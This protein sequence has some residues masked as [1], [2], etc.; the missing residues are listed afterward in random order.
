MAANLVG[1]PA[2]VGHGWLGGPMTSGPTTYHLVPPAD[3][4]HPS[5]SP[6]TP[7]SSASSTTRAARCS[8]SPGP[9]P[10]RPPP[11]SRRS[12]TG[13]S[14]AAPTPPQVLALTF[15]RKAAES[16]A[17]GSRR[18][19]AAPPRRRCAR[20]STPSPTAW[21]ARYSPADL[22]TAPLRL[23]SAPE[24]DVVLRELLTDAPESVALARRAAARRSATRGF[25]ARGRSRCS[26]APASAAST[27]PT[28]ATSAG[29]RAVPEFVAAGL[30]LG[31]VPPGPRL[32][33]RHRLRRP[34]PRGP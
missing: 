3:R 15:S 23:L 2:A 18:G 21:S 30:F 9:A 4:R 8:C 34:D 6:S 28:C 25:A 27:R 24:Q 26:R 7:T 11:W 17:T 19:S 22:Y 16:C 20:P 1:H 33:E 10:A 31:P 29:A 14:S 5:R 12:P 13:S 32:P